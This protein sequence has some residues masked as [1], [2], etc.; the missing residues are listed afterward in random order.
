MGPTLLTQSEGKPHNTAP[1]ITAVGE[2][3]CP[4]PE[5]S[6]RVT[7]RKELFWSVNLLPRL[8]FSLKSVQKRFVSKDHVNG[9]RELKENI[10][11]VFALTL[12]SISIIFPDSLGK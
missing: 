9:L 3:A 6:V 5:E 1:C 11:Y 10:N 7:A 12:C 4:K 8:L 2:E